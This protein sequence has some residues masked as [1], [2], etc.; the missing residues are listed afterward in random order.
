MICIT[1]QIDAWHVFPSWKHATR[2]ADIG[3]VGDL[4]NV[5]LY[6]WSFQPNEC[7][8]TDLI[9]FKWLGRLSE[10]SFDKLLVVCL[11]FFV[12]FLLQTE[13]A[14]ENNEVP[15][16]QPFQ[17]R[18]VDSLH[19]NVEKNLYERCHPSQAIL[20]SK[21]NKCAVAF[22]AMLQDDEALQ[23]IHCDYNTSTKK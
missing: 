16:F 17:E 5:L 14:A 20:L 7:K 3:S 23:S 4:L 18:P 21:N 15:Q 6:G 10:F 9:Q 19:G 12:L 11:I 2:S 8:E 1:L 13:L 22:K